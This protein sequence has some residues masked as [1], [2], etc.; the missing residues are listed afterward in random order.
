ME[1]ALRQICDPEAL[2]AQAKADQRAMVERLGGP[3][4]AALMGPTTHT[5]APTIAKL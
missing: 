5:P 3:E 1:K 4:M 2:D